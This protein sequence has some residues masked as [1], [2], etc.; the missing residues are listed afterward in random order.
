MPV[1]KFDVPERYRYLEGFGSYHQSEALKDALPVGQNSPQK[2]PYGLYTEKLSGT[3]FTAPRGQNQH[4][5]L[6][7]ILPTAAHNPFTKDETLAKIGTRSDL[8]SL[9]YTPTQLRWSPFDIDASAD[10]LHSMHLLAGRGNAAD[11]KGMAAFI[12]M[13]G[14]S[15]EANTSFSSADGDLLIIAQ[16]GT[17]DIRTDFGH[18]LVR[19][20][21]I[22]VIPR[23]FRYHVSLPDGPVRGFAVELYEGQWTL[24]NRGPIG[25]QSMA[26]ERDF[27]IPVAAF[28]HD[29]TSTFKIVTK[30]NNELFVATQTHTPFDVV[31]WHGLYYPWKYDL[32]RYAT[33]SSISYHHPDPSIFTVT[34]PGEAPGGPPVAEV[35][36]FP[37]R[38]LAM[39]GTFRPPWYHRNT[40]AE[41]VGL[42]K[43]P[44]HEETYGSFQPGGARLHNT[45]TGHGPDSVTLERESNEELLPVKAGEGTLAF[46]IESNRLMGVS[47]WGLEGCGK[48][49]KDYNAQ[50]WLPLRS[51]FEMPDEKMDTGVSN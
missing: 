38:W 31:A 50:T 29:T 23:G 45:M 36:V 21:E 7:R 47:E 35:A 10:W 15:M 34:A 6:Y 11:K 27:Q 24:P 43:S 40:M 33:I 42:I 39:E 41:L 5:W 13:A 12:Y 20:S 44:S 3:S 49:Q 4:S 51:R 19:P 9:S 1:T 48:R 25:S 14:K 26:N 22:C 32:G 2:P 16:Q 28:D 37:P 8:E 46:V 18:L 30:F 17:L